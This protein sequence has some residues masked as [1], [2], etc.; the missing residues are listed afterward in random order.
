[1]RRA[2]N[3]CADIMRLL[4]FSDSTYPVGTFSFSCGLEA[5]AEA[6]VVYNAAT[7]GEFA[8]DVGRRTAFT[9]GVAALCAYDACIQGDYPLIVAADSRA[10][11]CKT[12]GETR[13]MTRRMGRKAAQLADATLAG[14]DNALWN[15]TGVRWLGDIVSDSVYGTWPVTQSILFAVCGIGAREL[16][17]SLYYGA[18]NCVL[19]AAL[20][21]VRVSHYDTQRILFSSAAD[22]GRLYD[23]AVKMDLDD[24]N[25]FCMQADILAS[26]HEKGSKRMFMN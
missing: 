18:I 17:C 6:G 21:C 8:C 15:R 3:E 11:I 26:L 9:D 2:I 23:E 12:D 4:E 22:T 10:Y 19:S 14:S 24:M 20:R 1:M 13:L 5:A 25:A 7:L 16:F